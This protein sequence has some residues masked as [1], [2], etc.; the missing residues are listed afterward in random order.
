MRIKFIGTSHGVPEI[1]RFNSATMIEVNGAIYYVDAGAPIINLLVNDGRHPSEVEAIF[2]THCH[3]DHIN[4]L[5]HFVDLCHW[6]YG[7]AWFKAYVPE[8]N[9]IENIYTYVEGLKG[10]TVN[11]E[12]EKLI[13]TTPGV[14][15]EDK[16]IKVTA[17]PTFHLHHSDRP[18]FAYHIEAE[19]HR[20]VFTGDLSHGLEMGELE[21]VACSVPSD[22]VILEK[23]H[24]SLCHLEP[25]LERMQTTE[26]WFNHVNSSFDELR[27]LNGK[28][29][30]KV[31]IANDNDEIIL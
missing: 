11:R 2:I 31:K 15:Y 24:Y 30:F 21:E 13:V 29:P 17:I 4:M 23:A 5:P 22:I 26:L 6:F 25:Y 1:G 28:Y 12:R 27:D 19:G 14:I 20:V 3:G 16:N 7:D 8:E 9:V 10:G 18:S